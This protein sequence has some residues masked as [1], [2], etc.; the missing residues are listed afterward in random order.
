MNF[1]LTKGSVKF[2]IQIMEKIDEIYVDSD[3]RILLGIAHAGEFSVNHPNLE[4]L[5][6][7]HD[8]KSSHEIHMKKNQKY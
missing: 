2:I 8:L 3:G 4:G 5:F 7:K 6:A 1:H